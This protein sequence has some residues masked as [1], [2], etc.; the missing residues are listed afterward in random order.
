V[1]ERAQRSAAKDR[2]LR[3]SDAHY[4]GEQGGEEV[5]MRTLA[6]K[7]RGSLGVP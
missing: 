1:S 5:D 4:G 7:A 6:A 3:P 2:D